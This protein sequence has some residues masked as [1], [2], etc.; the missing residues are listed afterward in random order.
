MFE[1]TQHT[2][3]NYLRYYNFLFYLHVK[4]HIREDGIEIG[5]G[6][7]LTKLVEFFKHHMQKLPEH[8]KRGPAAII[9]QLKYFAG[10]QIRNVATIG[11]NIATAS[12]T[13]DLNPVWAALVFI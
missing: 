10:T 11:G 2:F 5:V 13:S 6:T 8:Q 12:P 7:T 4:I 1:S 3:P 9:N